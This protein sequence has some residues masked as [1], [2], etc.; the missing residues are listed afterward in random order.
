MN[1][2]L[3]IAP[4]YFV[5]ESIGGMNEGYSDTTCRRVEDVLSP[6][7]AKAMVEE[8]IDQWIHGMIEHYTNLAEEQMV[9]T[10]DVKYN[11]EECPRGGWVRVTPK[12]SDNT[13]PTD[14]DDWGFHTLFIQVYDG[15]ML[16]DGVV[17]Y[18]QMDD[19]VRTITHKSTAIR[20]AEECISIEVE[21]IKRQVRTDTLTVLTEDLK[22][23]TNSLVYAYDCL[24]EVVRELEYPQ[25]VMVDIDDSCTHYFPVEKCKRLIYLNGSRITTENT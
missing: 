17:V 12:F 1:T 25:E 11:V 24:A 21:R 6:E 16:S 3:R 10:M 7:L 15:V 4:H 14:I 19:M 2:T 20:M 18:D 13:D 9:P 23:I 8:Y 5:I 22:H